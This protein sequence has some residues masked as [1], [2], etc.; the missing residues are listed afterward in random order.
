MKFLFHRSH[1][2]NQ[3]IDNG[4]PSLMTEKQIKT[5]NS[6][7]PK[8]KI[9]HSLFSIPCKVSHPKWTIDSIGHLLLMHLLFLLRTWVYPLP[10]Q[11]ISKIIHFMKKHEILGKL[12]VRKNSH[13]LWI[14]LVW[15]PFCEW[16]RK[17]AI[18]QLMKSG[19]GNI[20]GRRRELSFLCYARPNF[21]DESLISRYIK[22]Y[23]SMIQV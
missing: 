23:S 9:P 17:S 8:L 22:M 4:R 3:L 18:Y 14:P 19:C 7:E 2:W 16:D 1:I 21:H 6:H 20:S 11:Q 12:V 5:T 13:Y 15:D 10:S